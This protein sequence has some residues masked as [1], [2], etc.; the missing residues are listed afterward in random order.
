MDCGQILRKF[1]QQRPDAPAVT[2]EGVTLTA[3]QLLA[4]SYRLANA[5]SA[6]GLR[7]G[8]AVATL[9][10]NALRS[11]EEIA[12]IAIGGF[13]RV[14]LHQGNTA[15][16]HRYMLENSRARVLITDPIGLAE[17]ADSLIALEHLEAVIVDSDSGHLKYNDVLA[18]ADPRDPGLVLGDDEVVQIG[19]TGGTTGRPKGAVQTHG[20]WVDVSIDLMGLLPAP[21]AQVD[22]FLAAGP[23]SGPAGTFLFSCIARGIEIVISPDRTA[24]TAARLVQQH[25]AT[26]ISALPPLVQSLSEDP[27]ID[28]FDLT[29][30]RSIISAGAPLRSRVIRTLTERF[31]PVLTFCYGQSECV[32]IAAL[33]PD[34][35][36]RGVS[37]EP[38]LLR[39]VGRPTLR[40]AVRIVS[41]EGKEL[42]LGEPGEITA[43]AAGK[44]ARYW[45][46]PE[47]TA[48]KI[49]A[50]GYV[51]T[52][53]L[54]RMREDGVLFL[55]DRSDDI[56]TVRGT[57]VVPSDLED[58][59]ADHP[60]IHEVVVIGRPDTDLGE[61]PEAV[62]SLKPGSEFAEQ[63][64]RDWWHGR[65]SGDDAVV[66]VLLSA[67]PL[68]RTPAGKLSR[69]IIR[70]AFNPATTSS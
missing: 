32:P 55:T 12:G 45:D 25:R 60:A 20:R 47:A 63:D 62:I 34:L 7:R 43:D 33:T 22:R 5:L 11:P 36:A 2:F 38:E 23:F 67:D 10:V 3:S 8:D 66:T 51:R 19:F 15:E 53:D 42:A 52:G 39:S 1:A 4:R 24:A 6:L 64:I 28:T 54:G 70:E 41:P 17:C 13:V 69:R 56:I 49:T 46:N 27:G 58:A 29:S 16:A 50:D 18:A 21:A 61:R 9:G 65:S 40:S 30:I 48:E 35:V 26:I 31:G 14:P 59:F 68:P 57:A 37:G 44:L